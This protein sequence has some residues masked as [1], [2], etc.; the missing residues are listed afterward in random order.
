MDRFLLFMLHVGLFCAVVSVP[1]SLVVMCWE[2]ADHLAVKCVV[3]SCFVTF[4]NVFWSS[5]E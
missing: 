3:F 5:S 2:K 4:P 1:C